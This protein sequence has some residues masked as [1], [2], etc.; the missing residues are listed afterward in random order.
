MRYAVGDTVPP[1]MLQTIH[2]TAVPV[3]S[4]LAPH[5][6]LQF[7][8]FAG[9]PVCN[10]HLM[11]MSRRH[12]E[13]Q[14][15]GIHQV[16]LFHSSRDEMLKYQDRLPFDCVADIGKAHYRAFG[17]EESLRALLNP[18]ILWKGLRWIV[19]SRRFYDTAENGLLGLPADFLLDARG[20][21]VACHYGTDADDQWETDEL[22]RQASSA[23]APAAAPLSPIL[24]TPG[25]D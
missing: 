17:V 8:R 4:R 22:L 19:A 1:F 21:V 16:V 11:T 14:A 20:R 25:S 15:A 13:I 2:G 10:F 5:T 9:C 7:R 12:A 18:R 6:H 3:P 23:A 24:S